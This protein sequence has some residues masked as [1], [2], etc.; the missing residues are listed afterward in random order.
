MADYKKNETVVK[1]IDLLYGDECGRYEQMLNSIGETNEQQMEYLRKEALDVLYAILKRDYSYESV[2]FNETGILPPM[3]SLARFFIQAALVYENDEFI[4][5]I[6]LP[7]EIL[8]D[9]KCYYE[10][11][12]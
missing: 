1:L 12:G 4:P 6:G 9:L 8:Q 3:G 5:I 11:W 7:F 10:V 2:L